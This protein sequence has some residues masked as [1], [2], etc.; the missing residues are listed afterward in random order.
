MVLNGT[1]SSNIGRG[2]M[3]QILETDQV[4]Y[5]L[6]TAGSLI[7]CCPKCGEE[8]FREPDN[9]F[10]HQDWHKCFSCQTQMEPI[11]IDELKSRWKPFWKRIN[12]PGR[13]EDRI[14]EKIRYN[15]ELT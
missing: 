10:H 4:E 9:Y 1:K 12:A 13:N 7:L 2:R 5:L 6:G 14:S 8:H 3:K 11:R 15:L